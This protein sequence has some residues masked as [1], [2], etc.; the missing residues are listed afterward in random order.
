MKAI[1]KIDH[2]AFFADVVSDHHAAERIYGRAERCS[3]DTARKARFRILGH[4]EARKHVHRF[5]GELCL[6]ADRERIGQTFRR[7]ESAPYEMMSASDA[8]DVLYDVRKD[9]V[10]RGRYFSFNLHEGG[11]LVTITLHGDGRGLEVSLTAA[12]LRGIVVR[13]AIAAAER[14]RA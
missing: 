8:I 12:E 14:I 5:F 9:V 3:D 13:G 2:L 6:P 4:G 1:T 11:S 7:V 10:H